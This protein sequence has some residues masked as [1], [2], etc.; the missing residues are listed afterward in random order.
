MV[1]AYPEWPDDPV[2]TGHDGL[3]R[4]MGGWTDNFDNFQF[5]ANEYRDLGDRVLMLGETAG[6]IKG[7]SDSVH[8]PIGMIYS[9]FRDGL[10][11]EVRNYLTWREA[12]EALG[13]A[14]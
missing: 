3:R 8:Q 5:L 4:V 2:Y 14:E 11:G 12:L 10:V 9:D 7:T 13:L 1:Y 6:Q